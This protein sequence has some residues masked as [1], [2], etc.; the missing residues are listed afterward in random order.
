MTYWRLPTSWIS[1]IDRECLGKSAKF[2]VPW[3]PT[4]DWSYVVACKRC[5]A[6]QKAASR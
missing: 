4:V 2:A 6:R 1:H 5:L 3:V